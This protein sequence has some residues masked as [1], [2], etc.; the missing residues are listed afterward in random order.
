MPWTRR[1]N[2]GGCWGVSGLGELSD[3]KPQA[4]KKKT[5]AGLPQEQVLSYV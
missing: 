5:L 4:K 3:L 1:K 2:F